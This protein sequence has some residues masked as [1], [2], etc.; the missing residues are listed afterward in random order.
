MNK[1]QKK[2]ETFKDWLKRF[3]TIKHAYLLLLVVISIGICGV[4]F[5]YALFSVSVEKKGALNIVTGNL[6]TY[7]TSDAL[8][9]SN[10]ITVAGSTTT[11]F[12]IVLENNNSVDAKFNLYYKGTTTCQAQ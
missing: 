12:D 11:T 3:V 5:S 7:L 1:R 2:K 9:S 6:Y 8:N 10:R 4:Y